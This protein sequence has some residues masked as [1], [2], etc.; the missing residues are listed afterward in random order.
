MCYPTDHKQ[1][2]GRLHRTEDS[3]HHPPAFRKLPFLE[4]RETSYSVLSWDLRM[5]PPCPKEALG[6]ASVTSLGSCP[7]QLASLLCSPPFTGR[8][9][10]ERKLRPRVVWGT[11]NTTAPPTLPDLA[12]FQAFPLSSAV[13]CFFS[14][15]KKMQPKPSVYVAGRGGPA[16]RGELGMRSAG[17]MG[18]AV[19]VKASGLQQSG[20]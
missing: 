19:A 17:W 7:L 2:R 5:T 8:M 20:R 16:R 13:S 18:Q 11:E 12:D 1:E 15:Q 14:L 6:M 4:K 9:F 10:G 3:A